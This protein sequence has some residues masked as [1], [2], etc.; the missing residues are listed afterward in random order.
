MF[1]SGRSES[2]LLVKRMH[3]FADN[4]P[5]ATK[6]LNPGFKY[7]KE[8]IVVGRDENHEHTVKEMRCQ[9]QRWPLLDRQLP[10]VP[11][12]GLTPSPAC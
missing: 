7:K 9:Q 2:I 1:H 8:E 11:C 12:V 3:R 10:G 4:N 5:V 6:S